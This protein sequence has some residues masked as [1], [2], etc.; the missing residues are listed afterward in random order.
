[1]EFILGG[2]LKQDAKKSKENGTWG[3][4][5]RKF[6]MTMLLRLLESAPFLENLPLK[7]QRIMTDGRLSRK[8]LKLV[9][10]PDL[11]DIKRFHL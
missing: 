3:L 2:G 5:P 10:C 6:F 8:I 1:M 11:Y 7:K 4:V 9:T